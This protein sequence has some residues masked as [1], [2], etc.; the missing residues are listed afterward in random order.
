MIA[1]YD[2]LVVGGDEASLC[3]AACAARSGARVGVLRPPPESKRRS[4]GSMCAVPNFVWR[5]LDLQD[6]GLSLEPISARVTLMPKGQSVATYASA[7]QTDDALAESG[8]EDHLLWAPFVSDMARL[9]EAAKLGD[10]L[11]GIANGA[12]PF[13][14]F[15][16]DARQLSALGQLTGSCSDLLDDYFSDPQLKAHVAAH[17]LGVTGFGG[18]ELGT[19]KILPEFLSDCA[20]RARVGDD[21]SPLLPILETI[22]EKSGVEFNQGALVS[23]SAESSKYKTVDI[24]G[25]EK[26]KTKFVFFASPEAATL[27]GVEASFAPL[28]AGGSVTAVMRFTLKRSLA[29]PAADKSAVFQII[30]D[31]DELQ[32]ARDCAVD[33]QLPDPLP[34]EFEFADNGDLIARTSYCPKAFREDNE[35]RDWTGQDR[36]VVAARIRQRL[37]SRIK[38]MS[39]AVKK[40]KIVFIGAD[41]GV[42]GARAVAPR[43]L[44]VIQPNRHNAIS[45]A[46]KLADKVLGH[47]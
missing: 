34:I 44:V 14:A 17:A 35:W 21:A 16:E 25:G 2:L 7:R 43:D 11:G 9:K 30:D 41:E 18:K 27:A 1:T 15:L 47:E 29:P 46:V 42:N 23:V 28:A 5:R 24:S 10:D 32:A 19:A 22:C 31:V 33:G 8:I 45:A 36:Q 40:T 38:G 12:A 3:A 26:V 13:A 37:A 4:S 39:G 20:W 6:Y